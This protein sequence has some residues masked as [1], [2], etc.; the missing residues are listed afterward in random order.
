[1]ASGHG[2]VYIADCGNNRVLFFLGT[3][4]TASSV[5]GQANF[6]S[7]L[8]NRGGSSPTNSSL[9]LISGSSARGCV[10]VAAGG[11]YVCDGYNHRVLFFPGNP[12]TSGTAATFVFGQ[13]GSM[14]TKTSAC[15][16]TRLYYPSYVAV[17]SS[18]LYI[19]DEWN[20]RVLG[21]A[22]PNNS[23]ASVVFGQD[24]SFTSCSVNKGGVLGRPA[25]G[26]LKYPMGLALDKTQQLFIA[27]S[28]NNRIVL[29]QLAKPSE[30]VFVYGQESFDTYEVLNPP[31]D[32]SFSSPRS[33][34]L[35]SGGVFLIADA[36]NN[37]VL[38]YP[39]VCSHNFYSGGARV[40]CLFLR[41][42]DFYFYF[43]FYKALHRLSK[44]NVDRIAD[45]SDGKFR[46]FSMQPRRVF[47]V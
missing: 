9:S 14:T 36:G 10:A 8:A 15:S 11:I 21:F 13:S 44:R 27:D 43:I 31:T 20:N 33:V 16:S 46:L 18:M 38:R 37:R 17:S 22:L 19:S 7:N 45:R 42:S 28:G 2:G 4:V 3:S 47:T 30:A 34:A 6:T 41:S 12:P 1:M 24:G 32:Y 29:Y 39:T 23:T 26:S 25:A 5:Y 35:N 40:T